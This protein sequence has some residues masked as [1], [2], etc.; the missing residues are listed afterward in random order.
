VG[1]PLN[2]IN[3]AAVDEPKVEI[4]NGQIPHVRKTTKI[5]A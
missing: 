3:R 5:A 1:P 4:I 2:A